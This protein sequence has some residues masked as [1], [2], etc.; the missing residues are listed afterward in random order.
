M[1]RDIRDAVERLIAVLREENAA[2]TAREFTRIGAF[3]ERKRLAVEG[4][5]GPAPL[6]PVTDRQPEDRA[7]ALQIQEL[8]QDNKRLLEQA[9]TVQ[10]RIMSI[11][12]EAARSVQTMPGYGAHGHHRRS[13]GGAFALVARA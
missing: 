13:S 2:L 12:A 10:N 1:R 8:V 3:T 11:L 9:I 5:T 6:D 7:L 4:L